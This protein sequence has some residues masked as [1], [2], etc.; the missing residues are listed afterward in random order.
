MNILAAARRFTARVLPNSSRIVFDDFAL[1]SW[2]G[3]SAS[4]ATKMSASRAAIA[5][6]AERKPMISSSSPPRKKPTPFIAFFDPVNHATHLKSCPLPSALVALIADF[7]AVLVRSFATP[8]IPC[9][10]TTHATD[11][12]WLHCASRQDNINRPAIWSSCP[13]ASILGM[14]YLDAK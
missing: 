10:P 13:A 2:R 12:I 14:P 9:A 3:S 6:R 8:A 5:H 1:P 4:P 7:D 11:T